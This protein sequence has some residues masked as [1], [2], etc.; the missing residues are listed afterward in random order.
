MIIL[1]VIMCND[2]INNNINDNNNELL[3]CINDVISNN[4]V[5]MK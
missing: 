3:I 5:I 1:C 4:N 2:N